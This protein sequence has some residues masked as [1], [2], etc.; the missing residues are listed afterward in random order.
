[1]EINKLKTM[2]EQVTD[3][4]LSIK[5]EGITSIL[6]SESLKAL[7]TELAK[8]VTT[9]ETSLLLGS[10]FGA[11]APRVNGIVLSY[12]QNRFERNTKAMIEALIAR[13]E[14]LERNYSQLNPEMQENYR[15]QY[16]EMLL[17]NVID[18]RQV[19]K[20]KWNVNGF[21]NL[22]TDESN[23]NIMQM[24][25]DT[26]SE[27][28]VL[29]IDTLRMYELSSDI[30]IT[31]VVDKYGINYDQVKLVKEK[32]VR[33]GLLSRKNDEVRDANLD[34]ITV[35]LQNLEKDLKKKNPKGVKLS[36]KVKKISGNESYR[37]TRLGV[38]FLK[39]IGE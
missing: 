18:E 33:L 19:E 27:L 24:F 30:N 39:S 21:I 37:I 4:I 26:L 29:D 14:L 35:Y 11:I 12:K 23:E 32:L 15:T 36:N 22:M 2:K 20:V 6:E 16:I 31:D 25:F 28:T 7:V 9:E 3:L 10:L 34:E 17:D 5:E 1:M 13:I 38:G 8:Q